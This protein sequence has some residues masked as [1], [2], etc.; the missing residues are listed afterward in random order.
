ML[1]QLGAYVR[2]NYGTG[3]YLIEEIE[4]PCTCPSFQ[5]HLAGDERP[6]R[7]HFHLTVR[8]IAL[9]KDRAWLNGYTLDGKCVWS[10]DRIFDARQLDLFA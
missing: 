9:R 7:P 1:V 2:T 10:G 4:G 3:P 8:E 6:S 5:R